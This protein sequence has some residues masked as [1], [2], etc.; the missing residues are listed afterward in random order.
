MP[1]ALR[2]MRAFGPFISTVTNLAKHGS[3]NTEM[4]PRA[5]GPGVMRWEHAAIEEGVREEAIRG[6]WG[7]EDSG[8]IRVSSRRARVS[9][10]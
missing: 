2:D 7:D 6:R 10:R 5:A 1:P 9:C 8:D 3:G 4:A